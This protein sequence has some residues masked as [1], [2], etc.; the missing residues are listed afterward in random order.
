M[1]GGIEGLLR[2]VETV[3][4]LGAEVGGMDKLLRCLEMLHELIIK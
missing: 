3:H 4:D 1:N 2:T